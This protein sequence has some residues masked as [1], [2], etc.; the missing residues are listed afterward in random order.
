MIGTTRN[1]THATGSERRLACILACVVVICLEAVILGSCKNKTQGPETV[2]TGTDSVGTNAGTNPGP[3]SDNS[4]GTNGGGRAET[5]EPI[6]DPTSGTEPETF[7]HGEN[8][9]LPV[10]PDETRQDYETSGEVS[11]TEGDREC[12]HNLTDWRITLEPTCTGNGLRERNCT[13]CQYTESQELMATGHYEVTDAAVVPTCT[14]DGLTAGSHCG[15]C[16]LIL[17]KQQPVPAC[18]VAGDEVR[19]NEVYPC[20]TQGHYD[21]VVYCARCGAELSR[22][23]V[24]VPQSGHDYE[25][26][27][28]A[29]TCTEQGYVLHICKVCHGEFRDSYTEA[30]GHSVRNFVCT[31]CGE[32]FS[33]PGLTFE[34]NNEGTAYTLTGI[35]NPEATCIEIPGVKNGLPVTAVGERAFF[36]NTN[37]QKVV[38]PDTVDTLG[39]YAFSYCASMTEFDMPDSVRTINAYCFDGCYDLLSLNVPAQ[40]QTVGFNAFSRCW[41]LVELFNS[42]ELTLGTNQDYGSIALYALRIHTVDDK[43]SAI[44]R[45]GDWLFIT[46]ANGNPYLI[47]YNGTSQTVTLPADYNGGNYQIAVR[48]FYGNKVMRNVTVPDSVT[49]YGI[50]AFSE[51]PNLTNVTLSGNMNA[52]YLPAGMFS[53][54]TSLTRA[55]VPDVI[56][57]IGPATYANCTSLTTVLIPEFVVKIADDAFDGCS[58]IS[59][60]MISEDNAYYSSA[61]NCLIDK[62]DGVLMKVCTDSVIP[63]D[64]SVVSIQAGAYAG[65]TDVT[66][67][68]IPASVL[69][70]ENGTF[71]GCDSLHTITV[72]P[73]NKRYIGKGNCIINRSTGE[74][75][76]GCRASVIPN[77]R[78]VT[79]IGSYAFY[80]IKGLSVIIIPAS[81]KSVGFSAFANCTALSS[82]RCNRGLETVGASAFANCTSLTK[83]TLPDGLVSIESL[84]FSGCSSLNEIYI[85]L[86]VTSIGE[87]AFAAC[88]EY[89]TFRVAAEKVAD[90][91]AKDWD[92]GSKKHTII[93]GAS[94]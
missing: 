26:E 14:Q 45:Q 34:L 50:Y 49:W 40:L 46:S 4:A 15:I 76:A 62:K 86:S 23:S 53:G 88:A 20:D 33:T 11:T 5:D 89:A 13:L 30:T 54:C 35:D 65:C 21:S 71:R 17:E 61:G 79:S 9:T 18:H 75:V 7:P 77:D 64:G 2:V 10:D 43:E 66:T 31:V 73:Q 37:I 41:H 39:K 27:V 29:P 19:E 69:F 72:S 92:G 90:G 8:D 47:G 70:I 58:A 16:Y 63:E 85:P 42:S 55:V 48:A 44:D 87:R 32:D 57:E 1:D 38:L 91:W 67:V 22:E 51:C 94:K 12:A 52:Y 36:G 80:D 3:G 24:D 68:Y 93:L 82:V 81:V 74:L 25:T 84:A 60:F 28:V 59:R 83:L 56:K 78:S 6:D